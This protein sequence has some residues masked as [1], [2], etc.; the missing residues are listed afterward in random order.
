MITL[1]NGKFTPLPSLKEFTSQPYKP[2]NRM[3]PM[4]GPRDA[5][6][7]LMTPQS[8]DALDT[9]LRGLSGVSLGAGS[10]ALGPALQ[11]SYG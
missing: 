3:S 9:K 11:G 4:A 5:A 8:S 6:R 1:M 10:A 7:P 2:I